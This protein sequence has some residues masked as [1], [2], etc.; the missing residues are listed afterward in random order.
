MDF[1]IGITVVSREMIDIARKKGIKGGINAGVIL[2]KL[3]SESIQIFIKEWL[4]EINKTKHVWI[5]QTALL[6]LIEKNNENIV[7]DY[8]NEGFIKLSGNYVCAR[9]QKKIASPA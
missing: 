3:D 7:Y 8:Y 1:N 9:Y 4:E 5:E 2:F 6:N